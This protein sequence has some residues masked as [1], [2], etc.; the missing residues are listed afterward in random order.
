MATARGG[1]RRA[2]DRREESPTRGKRRAWVCDSWISVDGRGRARVSVRDDGWARGDWRENLKGRGRPARGD[3]SG[4]R[5]RERGGCERL[6]MRA[7]VCFVCTG[8]RLRASVREERRQGSTG[9]V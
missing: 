7:C 4:E 2:C 3:A 6:T 5:A 8:A 1:G 9:M